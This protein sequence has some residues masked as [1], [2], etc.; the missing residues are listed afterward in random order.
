MYV[1][2]QMG[3]GKGKSLKFMAKVNSLSCRLPLLDA[4]PVAVCLSVCLSAHSIAS[5]T[6]ADGARLAQLSL[7]S[8]AILKQ[9]G[10]G[11]GKIALKR[12]C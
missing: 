12:H 9:E 8:W 6:E 5:L 3:P 7:A 1:C 11:K 4:L 10:G 2:M